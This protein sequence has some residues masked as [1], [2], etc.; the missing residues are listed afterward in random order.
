M[1]RTLK[2]S[3]IAVL[4]L[5]LAVAVGACGSSS[6]GSS[7]GSAK[8]FNQTDA[9][10]AANMTPHHMSGVALGRMAVQ[11]GVN[12]TVKSIGQNIVDAQTREV[13]TLRGFLKTFGAKAAMTPP[14][15]ERDTMDMAKLRAATGAEFDRMWLDVISGH[16]SAA[17]QM[18]QIEKAGGRYPK[19]TQLASSI[20]KTQSGELTKFNQL[21]AQLSK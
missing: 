12:P 20:I 18:A 13:G 4:L 17:I 10:F 7:S 16:H 6:G 14:I 9:A 5:A 19:A 1:R 2:L 15:D 3:G 21:A 8:T 11:K